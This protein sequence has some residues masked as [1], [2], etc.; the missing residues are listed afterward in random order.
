MRRLNRKSG[1]TLVE[2]MV[3]ILAGTVL[4]I[5]F[6]AMLIATYRSWENNRDSVKMQNDATLALALI[7]REIR[8]SSIEDLA[9]NGVKFSEDPAA[10]G[11][12]LDFSIS[13]IR[14]NAV[15]IFR[16]GDRLVSSAGDFVVVEG[17]LDDFAVS[18][19]EGPGVDVAF[20]LD[21]GNR[22][23]QTTLRATFVPRN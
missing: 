5:T 3:G 10:R 8:K 12:R 1:F 16:N 21:G 13:T 20:R 23:G 17:G 6:S 18:F 2:I 14:S 19:S 4:A 11:E 7:G 9:I 22:V 15:T